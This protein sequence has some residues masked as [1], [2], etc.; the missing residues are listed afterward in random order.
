MESESRSARQIS[1]QV[2]LNRY[3][4]QISHSFVISY[5]SACSY[6]NAFIKYA[7]EYN[8]FSAGINFSSSAVQGK[9]DGAREKYLQLK[10]HILVVKT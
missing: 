8:F 2:T 6:G 3:A 4:G 9:M 5:F 7:K 1:I 10:C